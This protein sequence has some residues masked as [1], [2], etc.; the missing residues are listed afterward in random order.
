MAGD[1]NELVD[2]YS[3]HCRNSLGGMPHEGGL[4]SLSSMWNRRQVWAVGLEQEPI[5]RRL[6]DSLV[7]APVLESHHSAERHI[8]AVYQ[9]RS[10]EPYPAAE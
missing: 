10:Q 3:P 9:P 5:Q 4:V 1:R 7:Q 8:V 6:A 2:R